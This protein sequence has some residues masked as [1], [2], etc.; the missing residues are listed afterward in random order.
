MISGVTDLS[1]DTNAALGLRGIGGTIRR[2]H[3][4]EA[5][6]KWFAGIAG[7]ALLRADPV[8]LNTH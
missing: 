4:A 7:A 8:V 6:P 1:S 5:T 3:A 2:Q